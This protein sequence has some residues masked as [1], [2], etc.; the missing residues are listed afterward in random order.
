MVELLNLRQTG[1]FFDYHDQFEALLGKVDLSEDYAVIF[2]LN[3]LKSAIQQPV[4]MFMPKNINQAYAI[5]YLQ[6]TT[7]KTL[8]QELIPSNKKLPPLLATPRPPL[9]PTPQSTSRFPS[10]T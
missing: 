10:R 5:A 9:L 6:E 7:L 8:Q 3:G 4:K 2:F 1:K